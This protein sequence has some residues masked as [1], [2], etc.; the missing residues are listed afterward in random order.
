MK[1]LGPGVYKTIKG[2]QKNNR[3]YFI[4]RG[5]LVKW[6][7]NNNACGSNFSFGCLPT[8]GTESAITMG[9]IMGYIKFELRRIEL[10]LSSQLA[11]VHVVSS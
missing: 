5:S 6:Y 1:P 3:T 2:T 8:K 9:Y 4:G 11:T 7:A 10:A